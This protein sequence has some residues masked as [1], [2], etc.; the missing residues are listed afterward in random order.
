M[1]RKIRT[2]WVIM[3]LL[4]TFAMLGAQPMAEAN[5]LAGFA[6]N[7]QPTRVG[8]VDGTVNFAVYDRTGGGAG[9]SFHTGVASIDTALGNAGFNVLSNYLYLYE[10][11]NSGGNANALA[12]NTVA[13]NPLNVTGY[14]TILYRF[15]DD[16]GVV[17]A[18][19]PF[20]A[21]CAAGNPA[22]ACI[23]VTTPSIVVAAAFI[24]TVT[25]GA[26]SLIAAFL[27]SAT[28]LVANNYT[29]LWGYTSNL[30]PAFGSTGIID[31]GGSADGTVPVAA[32]PEP[33]TLLL[34]G[35]GLMGAGLMRARRRRK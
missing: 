11:A 5:L 15:M 31:G 24:P 32:V 18:A 13:V 34:L 17:T 29:D 2:L 19:N 4:A 9:D 10:T 23:G 16:G 25:L 26:S 28:G 22:V 21:A 6:G 27:P 1:K 30:A 35:S 8:F 12:Q 33:A 3:G 7:T 14:G 20:G